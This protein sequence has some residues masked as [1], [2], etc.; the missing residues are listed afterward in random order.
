MVGVSKWHSARLYSN[1]RESGFTVLIL[2]KKNPLTGIAGFEGFSRPGVDCFFLMKS[3][4]GKLKVIEE[5][6][7]L[8]I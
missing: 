6:L 7:D 2:L 4:W 8:G 1:P 5:D 3:W